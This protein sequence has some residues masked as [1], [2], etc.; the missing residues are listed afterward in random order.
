MV[1]IYTVYK[2]TLRMGFI[3]RKDKISLVSANDED[4]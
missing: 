3:F 1:L 4:L 2:Y